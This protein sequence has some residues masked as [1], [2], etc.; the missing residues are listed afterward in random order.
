MGDVAGDAGG[1]S[2]VCRLFAVSDSGAEQHDHAG[3]GAQA[4]A[5]R[6]GELLD[7][8]VEIRDSAEVQ[9]ALGARGRKPKACWR[10]MGSRRALIPLSSAHVTFAYKAAKVLEHFNLHVKAGQTIA[11]VGA[12]GGGKTTIAGLACRFY[13]PTSGEILISGTDYRQRSLHWLQSNLGMV[14]QQP[15]LF[16]GTVRENIRYGR[17][18]R[19]TPKSKPPR[20]SSMP[21]TSSPRCPRGTT[22]R[23]GE[24]G[25]RLSSGRSS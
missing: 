5:E 2:A 6:I 1:V 15:H 16:S 20:G 3:A 25:S 24:G 9:A 12:T 11:L 8:D 18:R 13:E 4:S 10:L 19:P 14:L 22:R 23:S 17:L 7:T 21:T